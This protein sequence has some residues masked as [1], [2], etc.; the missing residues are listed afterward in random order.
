MKQKSLQLPLFLLLCVFFTLNQAKASIII[1]DSFVILNAVGTGATN[2]GEKYYDVLRDSSPLNPNFNT[3]N[4]GT[5]N[6]LSTPATVGGTTY[7]GG[8]LL[9][10]KGA[11]IKT[12][13]S[14]GDYQNANNYARMLYSVTPNSVSPSSYTTL[15][16]GYRGEQPYPVNKWD[17]TGATVDL[18]S[19]ITTT[20]T[21]RLTVYFETNG[22]W[23]NG[24]Q[25]YFSAS[26]DNNGGTNY[27]A[28]F[29]VVPEP[30][31][32]VL[33]GLGLAGLI[34]VRCVRRNS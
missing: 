21:Y 24:S 25:Q 1:S 18:L 10:L 31:S 11:E 7:A 9:Q 4:L 34:A 23:W 15:N 30:S 12:T 8:S 27:S 28:T 16:L 20:G 5:F 6:I 19:S 14:V 2:S 22:S 17:T 29:D 13:A 26:P 3:A 33:L 32:A